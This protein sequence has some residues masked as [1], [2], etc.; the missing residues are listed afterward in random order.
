MQA[1]WAGPAGPS[2]RT[3][4]DPAYPADRVARKQRPGR[5]G[6]SGGPHGSGQPDSYPRYLRTLIDAQNKPKDMELNTS[7]LR[8]IWIRTRVISIG[9]HK[10]SDSGVCEINDARHISFQTSLATSRALDFNVVGMRAPRV[11]IKRHL[12]RTPEHSPSCPTTATLTS[13]GRGSACGPFPSG[14]IYFANT[15]SP[16]RGLE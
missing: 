7:H 15:G 1:D 16:K 12:F 8:N 11:Y 6:E 2:G 9:K 13:G 4:G 14:V 5:A 10:R 3:S